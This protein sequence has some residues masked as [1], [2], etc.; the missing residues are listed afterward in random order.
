M[1]WMVG[2]EERDV[3]EKSRLERLSVKKRIQAAEHQQNACAQKVVE[4]VAAGIRDSSGKLK[5]KIIRLQSQAEMTSGSINV[6]EASHPCRI[7]KEDLQPDDSQNVG[8]PRK[9]ENAYQEAT[10]VNWM[11]PTLWAHI[12][13]VT[14]K[15][16]PGMSPSEIIKELRKLSIALF[17]K[18]T[19]QV[20][21]RWIDH[22]GERAHWSKNTLKCVAAGNKPG[23][24]TTRV[25]IL[26]P[27][28]T[29]TA[30]I[31][32]YLHGLRQSSVPLTLSVICDI[33]IGQL[34]HLAPTIFKVP[35]SDGSLLVIMKGNLCWKED[36]SK[37]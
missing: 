29:A 11:T 9:P 33:M 7:F 6:A 15:V 26:V 13:D 1:E 35:S 2:K 32:T 37:C 34:Q 20:I 17:C 31:L 10:L 3:K 27:Y 21:G 25:G 5:G 16:G 36:S 14:Q 24:L 8:R 12:A 4:D 28:P 22:T 23:G 30:A 18:L 19:S